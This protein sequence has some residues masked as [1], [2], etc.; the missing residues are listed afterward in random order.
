MSSAFLEIV[1]LEDG[2]YALQRMDSE[3]EPLVIIQFSEEVG[4]ML[5]DKQAA[6]IKA[7]VGAG[8]QAAGALSKSA[9]EAKASKEVE[10][11]ENRTI[12]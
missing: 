3:D 4:D 8:V 1:E 12:H 10:E 11:E 9:M 2:T 5:K 7:M 6:V